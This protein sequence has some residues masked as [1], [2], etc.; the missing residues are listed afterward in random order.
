M[1]VYSKRIFFSLKRDQK[2]CSKRGFV[3]RYT[4]CLFYPSF[5]YA[6]YALTSIFN[7][8]FKSTT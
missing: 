5:F 8:L 2:H 3:V 4:L 6:F 1:S 7:S